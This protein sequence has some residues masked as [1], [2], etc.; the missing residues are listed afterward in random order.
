[1]ENRGNKSR[2]MLEDEAFL[3]D[4]GHLEDL[5]QS[6]SELDQAAL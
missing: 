5:L 1:M 2:K 6:F 3:M 4:I